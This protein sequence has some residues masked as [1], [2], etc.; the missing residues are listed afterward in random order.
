MI[1][2]I[3]NDKFSKYM[4]QKLKELKEEIMKSIIKVED[5]TSPLS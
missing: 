2:N 4:K 3:P 1:L 5:L